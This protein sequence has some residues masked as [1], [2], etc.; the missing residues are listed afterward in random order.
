M[1]YIYIYIY[2][3][4]I[5]SLRFND[6]TLVL[7]TWRKRTPNNSSKCQMGFNSTFKGLMIGNLKRSYKKNLQSRLVLQILLTS[8]PDLGNVNL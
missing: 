1:S 6:L 8:G 2:I 7:L 4:D 5:S 3:Y